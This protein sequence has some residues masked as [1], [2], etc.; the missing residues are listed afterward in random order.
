MS[1]EITVQS[2][3]IEWPEQV[4]RITSIKSEKYTVQLD[5]PITVTMVGYPDRV[6]KTMPAADLNPYMMKGYIIEKI[7]FEEV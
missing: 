7:S 6:T 4:M 3:V 1:Q 5:Q 2:V